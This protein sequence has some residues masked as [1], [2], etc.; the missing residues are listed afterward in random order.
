MTRARKEVSPQKVNSGKVP[1]GHEVVSNQRREFNNL[2]KPR[3]QKGLP[4]RREVGS[5]QT[6]PKAWQ[7]TGLHR[8]GRKEGRKGQNSTSPFKRKNLRSNK[9][10]ATS[11]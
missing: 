1:R 3:Q 7:V 6:A 2:H 10:R 4:N 9:R 8:G 5:K 11:I